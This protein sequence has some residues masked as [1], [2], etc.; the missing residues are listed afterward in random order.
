MTNATAR[1]CAVAFS[2]VAHAGG[3]GSDAA[4]TRVAVPV[5]SASASASQRA[6]ADTASADVGACV[7]QGGEAVKAGAR[8]VLGTELRAC[9]SK[10]T[11][12]FYRDGFCSTGP[13]DTGVH[14]VCATVTDAF[15]QY[16]ATQGND[17]ITPRGEF[18]GLRDGDGWCLCAD[19]YRQ[20][21][22]AG[23]AP[24]VVIE[25]T[26]QAALRTMSMPELRANAA[27]VCRQ[28]S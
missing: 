19:R 14:V 13:D 6:N 12:G 16:S 2:I 22:D 10:T 15:L 28:P 24:S 27:A 21:F 4:P 11:T 18:P 25:A 26:D 5:N 9:P 3:C 8:N 23:V 20:A 7:G 17:L 1:S